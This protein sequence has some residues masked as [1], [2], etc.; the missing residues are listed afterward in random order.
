[1]TVSQ[2]HR[3]H[4]QRAH[5]ADRPPAL[6]PAQRSPAPPG[7]PEAGRQLA[8]AEVPDGPERDQRQAQDQGPQR[9]EEG[10]AAR[11]AAGARVRPE[12]HV[13]EGVRGRV[14]H[15]RRRSVRRPGRR[16][17]I[18]PRAGGH[19]T[20]GEDLAGGRGGARAVPDGGGAGDVQP[21]QLHAAR[22]AARPRQDLRHHRVRQVEV[23]PAERR[24]ALR[25]AVP[26]A[27][28]GAPALRQGRRVTSRPSTTK[29]AWTAPTT[30]ST[31]GGTPPRR[32][33]RG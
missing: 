23:L 9:L 27:R 11:P 2:G 15:L 12:R 3:G 17:R 13:Q 16:L 20:A 5:R 32:W 10:A 25:R 21:G 29:R 1:M 30:A 8:R 18:R 19:G 31:C 26:A 28:A 4:D 22:R 14:R 6:D 7:V 33:A 24:F